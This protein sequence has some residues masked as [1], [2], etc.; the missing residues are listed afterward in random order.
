MW[1]YLISFRACDKILVL[2]C[3][4]VRDLE[5][6]KDMEELENEEARCSEKEGGEYIN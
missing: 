5:R 4:L 1:P 2:S 3:F 6:D